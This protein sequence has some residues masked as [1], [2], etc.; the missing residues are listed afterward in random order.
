L[1]TVAVE[2]LQT[3]RLRQL[4]T[5][6][7]LGLGKPPAEALVFPDPLTGKPQS[8]RAFTKRWSRVS[9]RIASGVRWHSLRHLHASLLVHHGVDLATGA[10]RLGHAQVDTTL[11]AYTHQITPDDRHAADALDKALG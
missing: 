6:L 10:A 2:A 8:P 4:E 5:R 1:P 9:K 7:A 11:R 3:H